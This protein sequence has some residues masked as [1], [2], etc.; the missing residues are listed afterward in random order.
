MHLR[1]QLDHPLGHGPYQEELGTLGISDVA[2]QTRLRQVP[3][4]S[5]AVGVR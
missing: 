2:K 1:L 3:D 5:T 4:S